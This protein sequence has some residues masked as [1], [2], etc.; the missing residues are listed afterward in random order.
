MGFDQSV[1][2]AARPVG[3]VE[4]M[5]RKRPLSIMFRPEMDP[6]GDHTTGQDR[7]GSRQI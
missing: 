7:K 6:L 5:R 3:S 1:V 2:L 4:D